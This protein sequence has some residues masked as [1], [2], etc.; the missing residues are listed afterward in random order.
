VFER[1]FS[2]ERGKVKHIAPFLSLANKFQSSVIDSDQTTLKKE[3][4]GGYS[5]SNK[6][7]LV[8]RYTI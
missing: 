2:T 4:Q 7:M 5:L 1:W 6:V 8:D 3:F